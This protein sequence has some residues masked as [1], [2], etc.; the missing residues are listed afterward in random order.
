[1]RQPGGNAK[2]KPRNVPRGRVIKDDALYEV[3]QQ[4][5]KDALRRY[6]GSGQFRAAGNGPQQGTKLI[7]IVNE[8]LGDTEG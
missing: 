1:M 5:P 7:E 4:Q 3:A 8:A 2:R 6:H